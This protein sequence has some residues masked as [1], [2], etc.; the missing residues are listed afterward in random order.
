MQSEGQWR[1]ILKP[2]HMKKSFVSAPSHWKPERPDLL[3]FSIPCPTFISHFR[4]DKTFMAEHWVWAWNFERV[5]YFS[6]KTQISSRLGKARVLPYRF[7]RCFHEFQWH[8]KGK[9]IEILHDSAGS[10]IAADSP[11]P[12]QQTIHQFAGEESGRSLGKN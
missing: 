2:L 4:L 12:P 6:L 3:A 9:S 7:Q 1:F 8:F 11:I 10:N 5:S